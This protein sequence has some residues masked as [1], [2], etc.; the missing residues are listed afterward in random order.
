VNAPKRP[1]T[2][3]API[4]LLAALG[5]ASALTPERQVEGNVITSKRDPEVRIELPKSVQY[6]G[7]DRWVL[8]GIADC[9]LHAFVEA[10]EQKNVQ[11]LYWVQFEGYLPTRPELSH[12]YDSVK[13]TRIGGLDFYVDAWAVS[14]SDKDKPGSDSEHIK[15]LVR[16]KGFKLPGGRIS[17]RLVRLLD[18][19]KRKE[20]MII[21]SE[22]ASATGFTPDDLRE[23]GKASDRWPAIADGLLERARRRVS[24]TPGGH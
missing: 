7:A 2:L 19:A 4:T 15:T 9:E 8:Y 12:T 3:L 18:Q 13:H 21:Y 17:V 1:Y 16:T 22:D 6:V 23:G 20:L 5:S 10:G 24:L 14:S 11:R